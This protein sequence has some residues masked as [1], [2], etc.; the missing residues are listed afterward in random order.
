MGNKYLKTV[1]VVG[2][3]FDLDLK[4]KTRYSDFAESKEWNDLYSQTEI[5]KKTPLLQ[6]LYGKRFI[7]QWFD[8][9]KALYDYGVIKID[10]SYAHSI[11]NDKEGYRM[12]CDA[13]RDYLKKHV[14]NQSHSIDDTAAGRLLK[15][16]CNLNNYIDNRIYSFNY[17]PINLYMKVLGSET[18]N[19]Q[20]SYIHGDIVTDSVIL[21]IE[22]VDIKKL[23]PGYSFLYKSNN[24]NYKPSDFA[25][26]IVA[27][28]NVVI[29]GHSLNLMDFGYFKE[30]FKVLLTNSDKKRCLTIITKDILSRISLLDN[31]RIAGISVVDMFAHTNV[32]IILTD[33]IGN[34]STES[35]EI[36]C[37]LLK[38]I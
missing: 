26:D 11:E 5:V 22:D 35:D 10:G 13:F 37:K 3:G 23:S 25:S 36:F 17:T 4:L 20:I 29:F 14:Y 21:G 9:E 38:N 2:N 12:I 34:K 24:I 1:L 18:C 27:A 19:P 8:I 16:I 6:Y 28:K 30:Y 15:S 31:L 33:D 32:K 7:D